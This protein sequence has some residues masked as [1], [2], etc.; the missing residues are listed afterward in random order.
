VL[1]L[2]KAAHPKLELEVEDWPPFTKKR[3]CAAASDWIRST[4]ATSCHFPLA[5]GGASTT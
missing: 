5:S 4:T 3:T 1:R 2:Y